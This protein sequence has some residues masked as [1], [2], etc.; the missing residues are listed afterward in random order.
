MKTPVLFAECLDCGHRSPFTASLTACP[1]CQ[2]GWLEAR[3]NLMSIAG[4][5]PELVRGRPFDLWRYREVLPVGNLNP[6]LCMGEGGTPL[7]HAANLGLMLGLP[8]LYIKD[9]RQ[10]PTSSFKDRQ[11][12]L[13]VAALKEAGI[14]EIVLSSTGNVAIAFSAYAARAGIKLWA[15]L[16]SLVPAEKMRETAIYGT[17]V[18]KVTASYDHAKEVAAE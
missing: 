18:V 7:I 9:E 15:F 11:A 13:S 3:Y 6:D 2:G 16:T 4:A 5:F 8:N 14:N 17:Q 1:S 10:G 12:A